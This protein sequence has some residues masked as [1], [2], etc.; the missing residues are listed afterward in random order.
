MTS[1]AQDDDEQTSGDFRFPE[2]LE[3]ARLILRLPTRNDAQQITAIADNLDIAQMVSSMPHPFGRED[4]E[5]FVHLVHR[6]FSHAPKYV[7]VER[8]AGGVAGACGI[9]PMD[10]EDGWEIGYW[11]GAP[12][13]GQGLATEA[14]QAVTD[15]FFGRSSNT[16][17]SG[18]CR[19]HNRNSRRVLEKCGF[20]RCGEGMMR[21]KA[22]EG[23]VP[24]H[25]YRLERGIW[26]S[27][28]GW[29]AATQA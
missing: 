1:D 4:A 17:L 27:L 5:K 15:Q 20:Q 21:S 13:W 7:V 26:E 23:L 28:K 29:S 10:E 3:T 9:V 19:V 8:E 14:A 11:I 25:R 24:V 16:H 22:F 18:A 6:T 2:C 12:F